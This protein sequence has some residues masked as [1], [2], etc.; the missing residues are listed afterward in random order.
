[1]TRKTYGEIKLMAKKRM[2][3]RFS[4]AL[5]I[6]IVPVLLIRAVSWILGRLTIILPDNIEFYVDQG[7]A[8]LLGAVTSYITIKLLLKYIGGRDGISFEEFFEFDEKFGKFFVYSIILSFIMLAPFVPVI[9]ELQ[10]YSALLGSMSDPSAVQQYVYDNWDQFAAMNS[11]IWIGIAL[12]FVLT[13]LTI[14]IQFTEYVIMD[15]NLSVIDAMKKSWEI[16]RGNFFRVLFFPL[17]FILWLFVILFTC[18][19]GLFY[20][21]PYITVATGYLY[22]TLMAENGEETDYHEEPDFEYE[23]T[24]EEQKDKEYA[25]YYY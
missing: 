23:D 4:D 8:I 25:D 20:V 17:S 7:V 24:L 18:G 10:N 1:M 21:A 5:I 13:L 15:K 14:R 11:K 9:I 16:T 3:K 6:T 2:S 22:V 19:L 12:S